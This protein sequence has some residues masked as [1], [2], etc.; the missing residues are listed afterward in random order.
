MINWILVASDAIDTMLENG[1][2]IGAIIQIFT[3]KMGTPLF[4]GLIFLGLSTVLYIRYQSIIPLAILAILMFSAFRPI[5]PTH[6]IGLVLT[7]TSLAVGVLL[8]QL[9]IR[10]QS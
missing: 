2:Y 6:I 8:Y 5:I 4:F 3:E 9:F 1:N 10:R 7:L